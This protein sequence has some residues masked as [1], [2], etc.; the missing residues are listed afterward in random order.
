MKPFISLCMIVKDEEKTIKRCLDSVKG[1]VDEI[2]IVDTG[3]TDNTKQIAK[4]YTDKVY[5]Y[6][7]N[8]NFAEARNYAASFASGEWILVLDADEYVD[9]DN[10]RQAIEELKDNNDRYDIYAVNIVNFS[11][12]YG[13]NIAQHKHVRLYRNNGNI[14]FFRSIHEQ[15]RY[16]DNKEVKPGLSSLVI[17]HSGYLAKVIKNKNKN[18]RN[19][20]LLQQELEQKTSEAFD[21]FNMGNEL[22]L[23][24][25]LEEALDAYVN[26]YKKKKGFWQDWVPFCLC[27]MVE[28]LIS[29]ERYDDALAIIYDAENIYSNAVDFTYYK[30]HIFLIQNRYDDAREV[31]EFILQN[32][33]KFNAIIKSPDFRDYFPY[34]RLGY[35]YEVKEDYENAVKHYIN[36]INYNG[37][38]LESTVHLINILK[39]FHSEEEIFSFLS[40]HVFP[41]KDEELLKQFLVV[42]LNKGLITLTNLFVEKYFK[43]DDLV[44]RLTNLK[45]NIITGRFKQFYQEGEIDSKVLLSG[46]NLQILDV[47]DLIILYHALEEDCLSRRY[48]EIIISNSN[49]SNL[50]KIMNNKVDDIT[51]KVDTTLFLYLIEKCII[52]EK[53]EI[54]DELIGLLN[55]HIVYFDSN[56]YLKLGHLFYKYGFVEVGAAFYQEIDIKDYDAECFIN[57]IK[58]FRN[59]DALDEALQFALLAIDKK[60]NDYRIFKEAIEMLM[61]QSNNQLKDYIARIALQIFPDSNTLKSLL[62][63]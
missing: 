53:L 46:L 33:E 12:Q 13:E 25:K 54:I 37:Y 43:N 50:L 58:A 38:C 27:N 18:S 61:L 47:A 30:G 56:I 36:A 39:K 41:K 22:R 23:L 15:L 9:K 7:W 3:S 11:G 16:K 6:K 34:K 2:I 32:K 57:T 14:Q 35:I 52:F 8:N 42:L 24:G 49:L 10:L 45:L 40:N 5:D 44:Q 51:D 26:A 48:L 17:Y 62:V 31:F 1:I 29:L 63:A 60:V 59:I 28:C 21:L 4:E 55:Q 19:Q 20:S